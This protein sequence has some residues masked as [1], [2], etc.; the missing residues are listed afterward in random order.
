M[1]IDVREEI[2]SGLK[3]PRIIVSF[4]YAGKLHRMIR[5][6]SGYCFERMDHD[7]LGQTQW[8][9]SG[10]VIGN[11]YVAAI[12]ELSPANVRTRLHRA[13]AALARLLQPIITEVL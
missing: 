5:V 8:N 4:S 1:K 6:A 12:L 11:L 3:T 13:R 10:D 9:T 7:A 2:E